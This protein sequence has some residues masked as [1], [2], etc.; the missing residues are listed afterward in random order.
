MSRVIKCRVRLKGLV[1]GEVDARELFFLVESA[2]GGCRVADSV[3]GVA[4][5]RRVIARLE[6]SWAFGW[7]GSRVGDRTGREIVRRRSGYPAWS[8]MEYMRE[9]FALET[10]TGYTSDEYS[11]QIDTR[12][13]KIYIRWILILILD[14][15]YAA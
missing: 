6:G 12:A 11:H 14:R 10:H 1:Q 3:G 15:Y 8:S 7:R 5:C 2:R 9:I 13:L 4:C